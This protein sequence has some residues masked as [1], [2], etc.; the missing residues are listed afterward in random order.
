MGRER[1][2]EVSPLSSTASSPSSTIDQLGE[3]IPPQSKP[4]KLR[5][6]RVILKL[7]PVVIALRRDRREWVKKEGKGVDEAKYRRH[8][9]KALLTF[10]SLG[11]SYIKLGQWLSSRADI[12]P[13]PYLE[14]LAKLQDEVPPAPFSETKQIIESELGKI[15]DNF[16]EFDPVA[17]SGASLG[18]VYLARYHGRQVIV[19][20]GRP[21][22]ERIIADDIHVLKKILPLATRFIDPNLRFS[23]EGMLAQFIET[24]H[25]EMDYR[26]EAENLSS[27]KRNLADDPTVRIPNVFFDRTTKHVLTMEY[28]PGIKIT[29]IAALDARGID[30]SDL[31]IKIHRLFFKMLL[32]H[33]LFHADPH[34]GNISV[35]DNKEARIILYDFGMVGRLDNETRLKLIR[36]YLGLLDK[37]PERTVNVL[38]ELGTLE[39]TVNRYI[40]ERGISLSIQTLYGRQ[41]DKMEVKALMDL[42]NKTMSHF[43][44]RLPKNL[45][46][47]MRMASILE[48]IYQHHKVKF[49][50]VKVLANLLEEEGLVRD[51]YIEEIKVSAR[52][53]AKGIEASASVAPLLKT[54]LENQP[55]FGTQKSAGSTLLSASILASAIFLGSAFMFSQNPVFSYLGFVAATATIIVGAV[56]SKK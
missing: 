42:A 11:P 27:I 41:V 26:I 13:Q 2:I 18:Q 50:F 53:I 33:S 5:V 30:R 24:I 23:A 47:Y 32:H 29:D 43:P 16:E 10:I 56:K 45:A 20:V 49:Q 3:S 44:F 15:E 28:V 38:I 39:P 6:P 48:G 7:L 17:R 31:V 52:R 54:Y 8:A 1:E 22:I 40:V 12:L 14:V 37:D 9:E 36:L 34:P 46:L 55:M 25:E 21:N 19:K 4:S 35:E 51:A